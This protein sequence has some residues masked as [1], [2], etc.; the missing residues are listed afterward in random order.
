MPY[1]FGIRR[2]PKTPVDTSPPSS[3]P[4]T[5]SV[6]RHAYL[7]AVLG[8]MPQGISVFDE[9]LRLRV[10]NAGLLDVLDLP[11]ESVFDGVHFSDLIRI[12]AQRGEYGPGDPEEH[13]ERITRLALRF[14]AHRFERARPNG[15]THL[16]QGEPLFIGGRLTGFITTYTDITERKAAEVALREQHSVLQKLVENIPGGISLFNAERRLVLHN[17]EFL[18]LLDIPEAMVDGQQ[19]TLEDFYR[20]NAERGEYGPGDPDSIVAGLLTRAQPEQAHCFER[21]RPD[22]TCLEVRG[23]PLPDGGWVTIYTDIS[24]RKASAERDQLARKVFAHTPA[25]I[26]FTDEAHR[27]LS[28][29]PAIT[30][31]TGHEPAELLGHTVFSMLADDPAHPDGNLPG[32]KARRNNWHGELRMLRKNGSE[33]PADAR[34]SRVDDPASGEAAN[35]VWIVADITERKQAEARMRH[36][37][38]TDALTG[39]PNRLALHE[40][41]ASLLSEARRFQ[42]HVALMFLDLDRFKII[43]DT[44]G[45]QL[46]DELLKEVAARLSRVLRDTDLVARL[47]GDEF[48]AVLPALPNPADAAIVAR[49][50][51]GALSTPFEVD[52]HELHT[53][54]SIGI[55]I[56]PEDGG[57]SDTIL[58]NADT[59]MYHAKAAGRNNYQFY[60]EEMNRAAKERLDIERK[61][62]HA[63]SRNELD[64]CYQPQFDLDGRPT[65]VEA[66]VRWH[67]PV[68][69]AIA[70][71]RFIP[72]AEESG[73]IVPLGEWVLNAAC[74]TLRH[75]ID[76]GLAPLRMAVNVSPRQLRSRDFCHI[77]KQALAGAALP[78]ELL[79]LEITE[80]S[81]MHDTAEAVTILQQLGA[82]GVTLAIDDFGTGYSSLAHLKL[83][84]I[85]HLKIDR[86]FVA[87]IVDDPD[88][89]AI[90]LGTIA[91][92]HSLGLSVIAE[93][94]ETTGQLELLRTN[95]CDEVQGYLLARP[96]VGAAAFTFLHARCPAK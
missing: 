42:W 84:P 16:V 76:A 8:S 95:G 43:N 40:Q 92:A 74:R 45:H 66:L 79:E 75:W 19:P 2:P 83:L 4:D 20:Y 29:N 37:A 23:A 38:Q 22:G 31:M 71:S 48:V 51:V 59:A 9:N 26:M 18:R 49:K 36:I 60:A 56:F 17:R 55:S 90:A 6:R 64:L 67:H 54:P 10:W 27:I 28:I 72:L 63:I 89:R 69:G 35:Y 73:L 39:L 86:S 12:P 30:A 5:D 53:T 80:S 58:R 61:L 41:L 96:M 50:I 47:G 93:G 24:E 25:G 65:G 32:L 68:D 11:V 85:D 52:G 33:F 3:P 81:V 87:D 7:Q 62:R 78:A 70:P 46:G 34:I 1:H 13:V 57:D 82:M 14:E 94:V 91:L 21:T 77:V 88:D 44:L 15:R